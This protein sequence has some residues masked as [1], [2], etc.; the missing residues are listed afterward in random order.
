VI[1]LPYQDL[2]KAARET[3]HKLYDL[4]FGKMKPTGEKPRYN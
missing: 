2:V 1:D 3:H 4:M